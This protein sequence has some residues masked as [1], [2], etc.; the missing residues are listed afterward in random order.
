MPMITM[1]RKFKYGGIQITSQTLHMQDAV[2]D[3]CKSKSLSEGV[4]S[5]AMPLLRLLLAGTIL[6]IAVFH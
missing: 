3:L 4:E 5:G 1:T 2:R 6:I